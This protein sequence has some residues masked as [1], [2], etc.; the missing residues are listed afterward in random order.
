[1]TD[2]TEGNNKGL[3]GI[4]SK[5][6]EQPTFPTYH[7]YKAM[8]CEMG[9]GPCKTLMQHTQCCSSSSS[10][11]RGNTKVLAFSYKI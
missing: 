9:S 4:Q 3:P 11:S 10:S 7:Q 8:G 1:M 5:E 2:G 6:N